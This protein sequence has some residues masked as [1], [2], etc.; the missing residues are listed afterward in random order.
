MVITALT[1]FSGCVEEDEDRQ[2]DL[3]EP[4]KEVNHIVGEEGFNVDVDE[5]IFGEP[6]LYYLAE[7]ET[8]AK[9]PIMEFKPCARIV[10]ETYLGEDGA[11][12]IKYKIGKKHYDKQE[13]EK[14]GINI[15]DSYLPE[16]KIHLMIK[17]LP[18]GTYDLSD[19][20]KSIEATGWEHTTIPGFFPGSD[21]NPEAND[22][23]MGNNRGKPELRTELTPAADGKRLIQIAI[24][25]KAYVNEHK[26]IGLRSIR[27]GEE[28][29][30]KGKFRWA[31]E[32]K[33]TPQ[34]KLIPQV[35]QELFGGELYYMIGNL[36]PGSSD[37]LIAGTPDYEYGIIQKKAR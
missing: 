28:I 23:I 13:I 36:H 31:N 1:L 26:K 30:D 3:G 7:Q 18:D 24:F 33:L 27:P 5:N 22:N 17:K 11:E 16:D 2:L 37:A 14:S 15:E 10:E 20:T 35:S 12:I 25:N 8:G 19:L 9:S 6:G 32:A 29:P 34:D 4:V 21:K